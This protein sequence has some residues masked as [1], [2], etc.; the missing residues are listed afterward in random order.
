MEASK[1]LLPVEN[2][3]AAQISCCSI[4]TNNVLF[5]V[6]RKRR[7]TWKEEKVIKFPSSSD[8]CEVKGK[9]KTNWSWHRD[10]INSVE[11]KDFLIFWLL[12]NFPFPGW[13]YGQW[14]GPHRNYSSY[15]DTNSNWCSDLH[16]QTEPGSGFWLAKKKLY[17]IFIGSARRVPHF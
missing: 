5:D 14:P 8:S 17:M 3:C 6:R 2:V 4:N 11:R 16:W 1:T 13:S 12:F 15:Y 7:Q 9:G 10:V